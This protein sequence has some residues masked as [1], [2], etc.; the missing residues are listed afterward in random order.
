MLV[1]PDDLDFL[2]SLA[3][4]AIASAT[5]APGHCVGRAKS[6]DEASAA[7]RAAAIV[8]TL[9]FAAIRPGGRMC[10]PA[11]WTQD[12][13]MT[14]ASGLVD[15]GVGLA[16]LRLIASRQNGPAPRR[17]QKNAVIPPHA[18]PD[19]INFDGS[20]V[21]FPGTYSA[22]DDQGGEPWGL[23]PPLN[24]YFDLIWLA[25]M[26]CRQEPAS[27]G[28]LLREEI[29]GLSLI[30]RL[31]LAFDAVP[32]DAQTQLAATHPDQRAVDMIFRDSVYMTGKLL[33]PSM[34]RYRACGHLLDLYAMLGDPS[35][36]T[37]LSSIRRAIADS[38]P[39]T[40]GPRPGRGWLRASTGVSG[41]DDVWGTLYALHLGLLDEA[42][43]DAARCQVVR[44]SEDGTILYLA[45]VRHVPTDAD[46]A[47][48]S[49]WERSISRHNRY[50]NGAFWHMPTGWLVSALAPVAP[51]RAREVL[52]EYVAHMRQHDFRKG[53]EFGGPW[54]CIGLQREQWQN[55]T[56][57]PSITMP[58]SALAD[59]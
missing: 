50:Q 18:V 5:V 40:L 27:A 1:A 4:A 16:H 59:G 34:Q 24:N 11:I 48:L 6:V 51:A 7:S 21:F 26:L 9:G 53:A 37:R 30:R 33:F 14:Y 57:L 15:R 55:A 25:W 56:F 13:T 45:A 28:A 47:P 58:L 49:A 52:A 2:R 43:A 41:Q 20:P 29:D 39:A 22:G 35:P 36:R 17:L 3:R 12:F 23:H 31:Q 10:Y 42:T 46:A 44:A 32:V 54:E 38:L 19:H 8:N